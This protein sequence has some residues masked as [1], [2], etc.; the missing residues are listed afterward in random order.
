MKSRGVTGVSWVWKVRGPGRAQLPQLT[1]QMYLDS[2]GCMV[3]PSFVSSL[4]VGPPALNLPLK[5]RWPSCGQAEQGLWKSDQ[6]LPGQTAGGSGCCQAL[7]AYVS[8][9]L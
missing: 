1:L 6:V 2:G 4:C 8:K 5:Y 3:E 9:Y 7:W